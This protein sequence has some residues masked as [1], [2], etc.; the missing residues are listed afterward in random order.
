M[1]HQFNVS[2]LLSY[3]DAVAFCEHGRLFIRHRRD[4]HLNLQPRLRRQ[5]AHD[6]LGQHRQRPA[7]LLLL[8]IWTSVR[9]ATDG[10]LA[11]LLWL[12]WC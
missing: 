6:H 2:P 10:T 5:R 1:P 9:V 11:L 8:N 7:C 12:L 4:R 3:R